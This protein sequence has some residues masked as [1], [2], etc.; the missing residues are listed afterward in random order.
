[1]VI[2]FHTFSSCI[3]SHT[4]EHSQR[5][6]LHTQGLKGEQIHQ[7]SLE[8]PE[9]APECMCK[10]T[11]TDHCCVQTACLGFFKY[12]DHMFKCHAGI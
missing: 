10:H 6:S 11:S 2:A 4:F 1:M 5:M 8:F 12:D 3:L 7:A 9:A